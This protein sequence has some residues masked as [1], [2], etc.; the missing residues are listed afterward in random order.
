MKRSGSEGRFSVVKHWLTTATHGEGGRLA[1]H[2]RSAMRSFLY[3]PCRELHWL[4]G[5][6]NCQGILDSSSRK[7]LL[8]RWRAVG[9]FATHCVANWRIAADRATAEYSSLVLVGFPNGNALRSELSWTHYR[10][11]LQVDSTETRQWYAQEA[12][13]K[14]WSTR[15]LEAVT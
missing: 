13:T 2:N 7:R 4:V 15:A 14:I 12:S 5:R 8:A 9:R 3:T 1:R 11:P 6:D 10:P